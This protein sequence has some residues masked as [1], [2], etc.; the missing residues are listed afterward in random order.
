M[1]NW[2][3]FFSMV[4]KK[5]FKFYVIVNKIYGLVVKR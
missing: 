3:L 5:I 2:I 1:G 4:V